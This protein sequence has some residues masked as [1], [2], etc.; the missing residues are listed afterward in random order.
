MWADAQRDG[1]PAKYTWHPLQKFRN[2][3]PCS[4]Q[5][6]LPDAHCSRAV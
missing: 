6:I 1:C 5:Q 3:I 2:S 4:M